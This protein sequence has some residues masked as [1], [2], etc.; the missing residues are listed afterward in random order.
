MVKLG[1]A[2]TKK[3][4]SHNNDP[5][6]YFFKNLY[7]FRDAVPLIFIKCDVLHGDPLWF[8]SSRFFESVFP[9]YTV[10]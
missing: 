1:P 6:E 5:N 9:S 2:V 10:Y 8:A 3:Y 4:G 7:S